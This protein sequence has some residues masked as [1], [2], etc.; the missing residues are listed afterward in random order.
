MSTNEVVLKALRVRLDELY[1]LLR[2]IKHD[3]EVLEEAIHLFE[4]KPQ[5][6][7]FAQP[8]IQAP[9]VL[10][11]EERKDFSGLSFAQMLRILAAENGGRIRVSDAIKVIRA[12]GGG[13]TSKD[14]Y[15][16]IS[17][18]LKRMPTE[19]RRI[20]PGEWQYMGQEA[21]NT[22]EYPPIGTTEANE[23]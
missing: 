15:T 10:R 19:F 2:K 18:Q 6:S 11:A 5:A 7:T 1:E 20:G 12:R 22:T 13:K 14:L 8:S 21:E 4:E 3:I 9:T 23:P 17:T 16:T